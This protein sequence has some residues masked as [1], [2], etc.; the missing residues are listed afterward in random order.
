MMPSLSLLMSLSLYLL[1]LSLEVPAP[2]DLARLSSPTLPPG[3]LATAEA[4][5]RTQHHT[6]AV[7]TSTAAA[8]L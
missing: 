6:D 4:F 2:A 3:W 8:M 1:L 5:K 7:A